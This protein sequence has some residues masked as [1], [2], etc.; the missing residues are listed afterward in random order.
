MIAYFLQI[1]VLVS[2]A[3]RP[4]SAYRADSD[5]GTKSGG[6]TAAHKSG[7][8]SVSTNAGFLSTLR[9]RTSTA[10]NLT[11][12]AQQRGYS[13]N[14]LCRQ[15]NCLNPLFPGLND[16]PRLEALQWQ[17]STRNEVA[18]YMDFCKD[19]VIYDPAL[20]SPTKMAKPVNELVKAQDEAAMTMFV[21]HMSG[22]GYEAW[23][24]QRPGLSDSDCV[25]SVWKMVCF[26]Y[27]PRAAAG[28]QA[29][30]QSL[31]KRPCHSSCKN[32]IQ[33]CNVECCDESVQCAFHRTETLEGGKVAL[34][35][36][37]YVE[38]DGPSASCTGAA[39]HS[40]TAPFLLLLAIF[41]GHCVVGAV[42]ENSTGSI[43]PRRGVATKG[44]RWL[45]PRF[46]RKHLLLPVFAALACAL[47]GCS[48]DVKHPKMNWETKTSYLGRFSYFPPTTAWYRRHFKERNERSYRS[49]I[50]NTCNDPGLPASARC[51]GRGYCMAYT[52]NSEVVQRTR[53]A[54]APLAFCK[55][56]EDWADPE[57]ST[58]RKSQMTAF[59][60]SL[61]LG[62]FG[63]DYFYL[64][65]YGWGLAK[66]AVLCGWGFGILITL[67][68]THWI[69]GTVVVVWGFPITFWWITDII[70]TASGPIYAYNFRTAHDLP[71]WVAMLTIIS[72]GIV[73]GFLVGLEMY[74]SYR[75]KK[76]ADM[77]HLQNAEAAI[78]FERIRSEKGLDYLDQYSKART[79]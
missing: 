56:E 75:S 34:V 45:M 2:I 29:G 46:V 19:I 25:R 1:A 6:A 9:L 35:K 76:R 37:G 71:H 65:F 27:F 67:L 78:N 69:S 60:Y 7:H 55:C 50:L 31:Y 23:D 33:H 14:S 53:T 70:R 48:I 11:R 32:Y 54:G 72:I 26:T 24:Y 79:V 15:N 63:A 42:T 21:Y 44:A 57:C 12:I 8:G 41:A 5:A 38:A 64:G 20:P 36:T 61:F 17:C 30:Q 18:S 4:S 62:M 66:I 51:N 40:V 47:Q 10:S 16:L 39:R 28:C 13:E 58:R 49:A 3:S 22:M 74:L 59:F 43:V 77:A 52:T 68:Y 73:M